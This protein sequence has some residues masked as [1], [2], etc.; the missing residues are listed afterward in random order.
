MPCQDEFGLRCNEATSNANQ[1]HVNGAWVMTFA[2]TPWASGVTRAQTAAA[3][4]NSI[5]TDWATYQRD[6]DFITPSYEGTLNGGYCVVCPRVL[7]NNGQYGGK[8][9]F[10]QGGCGYSC[11]PDGNARSGT[12]LCEAGSRCLP[13]NLYHLDNT[14]DDRSIAQTLIT[15]VA[16]EDEALHGK[17]RWAIALEF[18]NLIRGAVV[19]GTNGD[20]LG[21][22]IQQLALANNT[23][24][25]GTRLHTGSATFYGN[26]NPPYEQGSTAD[27][28]NNICCVTTANND[29]FHPL[30]LTIAVA[31]EL[32]DQWA[33]RWL[34]VDFAGRS[35]VARVTDKS[36]PGGP[37]DLSY[38]GVALPLGFTGSGI[39]DLWS[40]D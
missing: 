24:P 4:L 13:E 8:T 36:G 6:L 9:Y 33:N 28:P 7:Y 17:K 15:P 16:I 20:A 12:G 23:A 29:I 10:T 38:G 39:V 22:T 14:S 30:D 18:A 21:R 40:S 2:D 25:V 26:P 5:F 3:R 1:T 37:V 32:Y 34:R 27:N 35:V 31:N 11:P 19:A